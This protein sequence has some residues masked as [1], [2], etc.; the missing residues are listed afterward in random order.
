MQ[1]AP[2]SWSTLGSSPS[3]TMPSTTEPTGW[4][5]RIIDVSAAGRRGSETEISSQPS[6][7]ELSASSTSQPADGHAGHEVVDAERERDG[8]RRERR[9]PGRVE[10]RPGRPPQVL[11]AVAQD[12]DEARVGDAGQRAE[13]HAAR[14]VRAVGAVL[15][16]AR[17]QHD[18]DHRQRQRGE[19]PPAGRLREHRPG[20][21]RDDHDLQV[22]E[23]GRQPGADVGDR[24]VP[25]DQVGGEEQPGDQR[26]PLLARPRAGRSGAARATRAARAAGTA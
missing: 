1:A 17:D 9:D 20:D 19:D 4:T 15:E 13:Q 10:Q 23:H 22:A 21:E 6:T 2:Q 7:C 25:E 24:L 26:Q 14:R 3:S 12:Q 5:V 16:R 11:V 18:A 8:E